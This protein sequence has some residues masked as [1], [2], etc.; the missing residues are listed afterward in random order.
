MTRGHLLNQ[1]ET[2]MATPPRGPS[3]A[4]TL[5]WAKAQ[6]TQAR[7]A[8]VLALFV[9]LLGLWPHLRFSIDVGHLAWFKS[10]F[11][12]DTYALFPFGLGHTR[13]DRTGS[14]AVMWMLTRAGGG[15]LEAALILADLL[16]PALAAAS[17]YALASALVT[18]RSARVLVA[19]LLLF[20]ADLLSLGNAAVFTGQ[21]LSLGAF[22]DLVGPAAHTLVPAYETSYLTIFRTPE[23]Q[24]AHIVAF[25]ALAGLV[26]VV[27]RRVDVSRS[28][29]WPALLVMHLLVVSS[30]VYIA[31]LAVGIEF[32]VGALLLGERRLREARVLWAF[33][34][35]AL[36]VIA[37]G[38]VARTA[39][40]SGLVFRSH[41]P[42]LTPSAVVSLLATAAAAL[43]LWKAR[44]RGPVL[45]LGAALAAAPAVLLNQ[46]VLTGIMVSAREWERYACYPPLVCGCAL[47]AGE[48]LSAQ[49]GRVARGV[50]VSFDA[51]MIAVVIVIGWTLVTAQGRVYDMWLRINQKSLA[52]ADALGKIEVD[53]DRPLL[54]VLDEPT[55]APL[56]AVRRGGRRE[57]LLD[58]T[59]VFITPVPRLG[60]SAFAL[61][62][63]SEP[64]FEYWRRGP[65]S[66]AQAAKL[67]EAEI[68]ARNGTALA[69]L[70]HQCD[71]WYPCSD[72]RDLQI[73]AIRSSVP[74]IVQ[75]YSES[76]A[77]PSA[78]YASRRPLLIAQAGSPAAATF[79]PADRLATATIATVRVHVYGLP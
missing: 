70:F 7:V 65:V 76:L 31:I 40:Q 47:L 54:L 62:P 26:Q 18:A 17:A 16:L 61:T 53:P 10:A 22:R 39:D 2:C 19:L 58:V 8:A 68:A 29:V 4:R 3:A 57:S 43:L 37:I 23:P 74:A 48:A 59:D 21:L 49:R 73:E 78:R 20:G 72:G 25:A 5:A 67:L 52:I 46:Q 50:K 77:Q 27:R 34:A 12:E 35:L 63:L 45:W 24:T 36:A 1:L 51:G 28:G 13:L 15:S 33:G 38:S 30:Y 9:G 44:W 69:F 42:A 64:L 11:D 56:V 14:G 60:R 75:A 71:Y 66:A 55:L 41:L 79:T 32:V 6:S